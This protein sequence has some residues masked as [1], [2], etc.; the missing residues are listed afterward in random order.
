[1]ERRRHEAR[2]DSPVHAAREQGPS[3]Q[4]LQAGAAP[5]REQLGSEVDLPG[6]IREKMEN[7]F[8]ADLSSVRLYESQA[9]ADA[10][11]QA[12]AMGNN[13]AFAPGQLDFT[14]TAGQSLLGHELS[15]V[16]SQARGE[17]SGAGFLNDSA[18]EARADR[19]G[20]MAAAG[21]SVYTGPVTPLSASSVAGAAGP[22]QAK[23]FKDKVNDLAERISAPQYIDPARGGFFTPD[24]N[25]DELRGMLSSERTRNKLIKTMVSQQSSAAQKIK[26]TRA[27]ETAKHG[28][29]LG[30][31]HAIFSQAGDQFINYE[32]LREVA[33]TL[34]ENFSRDFRNAKRGV[35]PKVS[36]AIRGARD[37]MGE[38]GDDGMLG[39]GSGKFGRELERL[40][41]E[42]RKRYQ[43]RYK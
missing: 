25:T 29:G 42:R 8:G 6:A 16:V 32:R 1:M 17:V 33:G 28:E 7:S 24:E 40:R 2:P 22:M 43:E 4:A 35:K 14:S 26:K 36:E 19:E 34:D 38:S 21:E 15:H 13:I 9:V 37:L 31:L 23:K 39:G 41:A 10:G 30:G 12:M 18:L 5:T 3:L 11:A 20:A 27:A